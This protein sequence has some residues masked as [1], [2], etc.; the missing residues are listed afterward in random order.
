[1]KPDTHLDVADRLLA[2]ARAGDY[3]GYDP[4]DGLN[5]RLFQAT[6]LRRWPLARLAWLQL[7]KRLPINLRPVTGV[8]RLR[9]PKGVGLFVLGLLEQWRTTG[10]AELLAEACRLADWLLDARV[11]PSVW[12]HSAWGYHFD[13]EARAFFVPRGTP[14]AITTCYVSGA[15]RELG[16]ASGELRYEHAANDAALFLDR[17][18]AR[19]GSDGFYY[20][21]VPGDP[22]FVHN[23][24]LW[25][26]ARVAEA[27]AA[28]GDNLLAANALRAA[29][30]SVA[31]QEDDG[32][33]WYGTRPHHRFVDGFHTGYNLEA[34]VR[35]QGALGTTEFQPSIERGYDYYKRH[36]FEPNGAVR[37]FAGK[38]WPEETHSSCQAIV[39]LVRVGG[40]RDHALA[41]KVEGYMID[42][43][44]DVGRECFIYRRSRLLRNGVD[45][46][47]WS[48]AWA[49]YA[50]AILARVEAQRLGR[51]L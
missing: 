1:M 8:P 51:E 9:N 26:A 31:M 2:R 36:F 18:M 30:T 24:N 35:L 45:Y 20:G 38:R 27:A 21:Y 10:D 32:S 4:F 34:L 13:W 3:A 11:D 25:V 17:A 48:Q 33:W 15:L 40:S 44:Y 12:S 39:T 42:N 41:L 29:R 47:R 5:S 16:M 22:T 14:N 28:T 49:F 23:A 19:D 37:Y 43:F 46:A 50:L 6:P 7:F